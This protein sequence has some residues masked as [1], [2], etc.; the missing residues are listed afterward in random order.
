MDAGLS[1]S[2]VGSA[3]Q[4]KCMKQVAGSL[5]LNLANYSELQAFSQF[6]SDLDDETKLVLLHGDKIMQ[7]IKQK[8]ASPYASVDQVLLL[9]IV[10]QKLIDFIPNDAMP[11][12][13]DEILIAFKTTSTRQDIDNSKAIDDELSL[14]LSY[15]S[16]KFIVNFINQIPDYQYDPILD[17]SL[18]DFSDDEQAAGKR[19]KTVTATEKAAK[20]ETQNP[21]AA[22][23]TEKT[24]KPAATQKVTQP[25]V[26]KKAKASDIPTTQKHEVVSMQEFA[27]YNYDKRRKEWHQ[28]AGYNPKQVQCSMCKQKDNWASIKLENGKHICYFCWIKK[29]STGKVKK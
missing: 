26:V 10:N 1:V 21:A 5:K 18:L 12:F 11:T 2:R 14:Q 24:T 28:K 6:G 8:Q 16:K 22:A 25:V 7:T 29:P 23:P 3:A 4:F 15:F 13:K 9:F 20:K 17:K 19:I 27:K